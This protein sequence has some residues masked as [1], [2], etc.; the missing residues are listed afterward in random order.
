MGKINLIE[1]LDDKKEWWIFIT[2]KENNR[3]NE[4]SMAERSWRVKDISN[5]ELRWLL[6]GFELLYESKYIWKIELFVKTLKI[7]IF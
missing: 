3:E 4:I 2:H 5:Q 6:E 1:E 7:Y